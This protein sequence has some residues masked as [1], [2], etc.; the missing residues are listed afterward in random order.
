MIDNQASYFSQIS[1]YKDW[2]DPKSGFKYRLK[3]EL[4][5]FRRAHQGAIRNR[6][7]LHNS[8]YNLATSSLTETIAWTNGL[9][10]YIDL[11]YE[12]YASGKFGTTKAWHVTTKLAM[13]LITEVGKPREGALD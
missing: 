12:E 1:S 6:I 8:L 7:S 9:I 4:D 13:A 5:K 10:N 3:K 11:T 2:N